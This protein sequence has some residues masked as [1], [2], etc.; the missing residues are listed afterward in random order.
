MNLR[1]GPEYLTKPCVLCDVDVPVHGVTPEWIM[2]EKCPEDFSPWHF[3]GDPRKARAAY[4]R[5]RMRRIEWRL[6][7]VK[8]KPICGVVVTNV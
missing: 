4:V 6:V 5:E 7:Q 3:G 2:C 8:S 1:R